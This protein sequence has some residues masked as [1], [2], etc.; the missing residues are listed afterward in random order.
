MQ[1]RVAW[2]TRVTMEHGRARGYGEDGVMAASDR[3][4]NLS[5]VERVV[6]AIR[7]GV[8]AGRFVP[9]QR[10]VEADLVRDLG[11]GRNALR[12]GLARLAS[13]GLVLLEA[14]R[15]ASIRRLSRQEIV[16]FYQLREVL[17][18]LA[19]RLAAERIDD[20]GHRDRLRTALEAF[21]AAAERGDLPAAMDENI[22]FHGCI[23]EISG[24]PRLVELID[25]LQIQTFRIQFRQVVNGH[26]KEYSLSE[27]ES[28]ADAIL[29]GDAQRA[30]ELMRQHLRHTRRGIMELP[31]S[32]FA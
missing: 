23:V 31:D 30:E 15:G 24:H 16:D 10:L 2:E 1:V 9:G 14:H 32:A 17:E 11:I 19:A 25:Q 6:H 20:A 22:R 21:R 18:G 3:N 26:M 13:E 12:E 27:H 5:A 8:K 4:G 29:A 28:L 7:E